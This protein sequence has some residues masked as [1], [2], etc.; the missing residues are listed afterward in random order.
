MM[1]QIQV[2]QRIIRCDTERTRKAYAAMERGDAEGVGVR[3]AETSQLSAAPFTLRTSAYFLI[4]LALTRRRREK[5]MNA[6]PRIR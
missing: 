5:F 1:D 2:G 3:T 4:S 6:A